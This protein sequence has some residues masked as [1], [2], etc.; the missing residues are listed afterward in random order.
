MLRAIVASGPLFGVAVPVSSACSQ[1]EQSAADR[2]DR[3]DNEHASG[4]G[5]LGE[6]L[7]SAE[8]LS[9]ET[10]PVSTSESGG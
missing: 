4:G 3:A 5:V 1:P 8:L 9:Q 6:R 10:H 2:A 7:A